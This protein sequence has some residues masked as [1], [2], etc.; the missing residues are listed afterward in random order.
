MEGVKKLNSLN[1]IP[2]FNFD[3]YIWK[4]DS[5]NP[6]TLLDKTFDFSTIE[7]NPFIMEGLLYNQD[8]NKS[9][10]ITHDGDYHIVEYDLTEL[11]KKGEFIEKEFNPHRLL[12]LIKKVKF[13]QIW[14]DEKDP[15][16]ND[17]LVLTLKATVF[18][19]FKK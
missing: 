7:L 19:G 14:M 16:C 5:E 12:N 11:S 1:E 2:S 15:N 18:C 4:S 8:E 6:I 9:Y 10:H 13:N 3:G 17:L